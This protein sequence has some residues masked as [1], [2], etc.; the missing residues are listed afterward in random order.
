VTRP[1][2]KDPNLMLVLLTVLSLVVLGVPLLLILAWINRFLRLF[3]PRPVPCSAAELPRALVVL[4]IRG[5]DPSLAHCL[6]GLLNQDYPRFDIRIVIDSAE[7]PAWQ[8]VRRALA[9]RRQ[10]NVD[11]CTL[12]D[13]QAT[14]S[15][16]LSALVQALRDL[17]D[18]CEVVV[19]IDADVIPHREWLRDLVAPLANP[20]VGATTGVRWYVPEG[21]RWGTLVR[22]L[23]NTTAAVVMHALR[24]PW[25][26]SLAFR[27]DVLRN[28]DT[29]DRW[30]LSLF[31]DTGF[32]R[33]I[34]SLGLRLRVV[35]A[36]TMINRESTDLG[37]CFRFIRRQLLNTRLYHPRWPVI[38]VHGLAFTLSP[39]LA[40]GVLTA[41]L[42]LG[43]W[44]EA[45]LLAGG[46]GVAAA[47]LAAALVRLERQV[48]GPDVPLPSPKT[49]A[50]IPLALGVYLAGLLWAALMRRVD[51]RGITYE[52]RGP[53]DVR[54][55]DYQPYRPAGASADRTAS[56]I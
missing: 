39:L 46:L 5:A 42:L 27:A 53:W 56:L 9:G 1:K 43:H 49:V 10:I 15:L 16:K 32:Q 17:D 24:I 40:L 22:H 41:A 52:F 50:A 35:P 23:W 47:L 3:P 21:T 19:L 36:A 13:R 14:C 31:E 26:G 38:F 54:L 4:A 34:R 44:T 51:W 12:E 30:S 45:A 33:V 37:S 28:S 18:A 25:G 55:V 20:R 7:D 29:L 48:R 2:W 11:V 8:V 6:D